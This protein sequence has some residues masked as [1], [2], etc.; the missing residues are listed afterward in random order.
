MLHDL[1]N[2]PLAGWQPH[3]DIPVTKALADQQMKSLSPQ[4]KWL[5]AYLDSGVLDH[6]HKSN[7]A[8]VSAKGFFAKALKQNGMGFLSDS[9]LIEVM[10]EFGCKRKRSNGSWWIFPPLAEMRAAWLK[11]YPFTPPFDNDEP[12]EWG[13]EEDSLM[14][15]EN[16]REDGDE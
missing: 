3:I 10:E 5:Y 12:I 9:D 16:R 6:Q 4:L 7:P 8:K 11:E 2:L 13:V 15:L 1:K 14:S